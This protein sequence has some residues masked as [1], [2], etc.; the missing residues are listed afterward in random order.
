MEII[1]KLKDSH[2]GQLNYERKTDFGRLSVS[3]Y[4][5]DMFKIFLAPIFVFQHYRLLARLHPHGL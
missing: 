2:K 1:S 3:I 4:L 5:D